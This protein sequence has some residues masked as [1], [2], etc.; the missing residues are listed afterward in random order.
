MMLLLDEIFMEVFRPKEF[1]VL[2]IHLAGNEYEF[3]YEYEVDDIGARLAACIKNA[4]IPGIK[5]NTVTRSKNAEIVLEL[6]AAQVTVNKRRGDTYR[7]RVGFALRNN[8]HCK[9]VFTNI[10]VEGEPG[11][12]NRIVTSKGPRFVDIRMTDSVTGKPVNIEI[13][14]G[15]SR[16]HVSQKEKDFLIAKAN[17]GQT[18]VVRGTPKRKM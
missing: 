18:Y 13:K 10:K 5:T 16:Y 7:D 9:G 12:N 2:E 17:K 14:R 3:G 4:G 8:P 15:N 6:E 1:L 11:A